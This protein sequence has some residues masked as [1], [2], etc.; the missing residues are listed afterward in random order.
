MP[1]PVLSFHLKLCA[2]AGPNLGFVLLSPS[3]A[4]GSI[5]PP[6]PTLFVSLLTNLT[7]KLHLKCYI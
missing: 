7:L 2:E 4:E 1:L 3:R 6:Q 5:T